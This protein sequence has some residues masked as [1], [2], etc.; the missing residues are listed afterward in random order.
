MKLSVGWTPVSLKTP[1]HEEKFSLPCTL[2]FS[3]LTFTGVHVGWNVFWLF[4]KSIEVELIYDVVLYL[5]YSK[6]M[7]L[8][9]FFFLTLSHAGLS[10][11]VDYRS[12]C[13]TAG[14]RRVSLL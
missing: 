11:D 6:V 12:L 1:K 9:M 2:T 3:L 8:Y 5:L 7:Q 14:P 10:Q 4:L 13:C